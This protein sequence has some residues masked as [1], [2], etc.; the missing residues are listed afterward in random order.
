MQALQSQ[1]ER[2]KKQRKSGM[3][4]EERE[5]TAEFGSSADKEVRGQRGGE[6]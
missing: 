5:V 2:E 6:E 3:I 4:D 1:T